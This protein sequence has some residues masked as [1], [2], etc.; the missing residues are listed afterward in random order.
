MYLMI[1]SG[2]A[3]A[4]LSYYITTDG[5]PH[6]LG[7]PA[8]MYMLSLSALLVCSLLHI[9]VHELGHVIFG[10]LSG[11]EFKGMSVLG[12]WTLRTDDGK[13]RMFFPIA[14]IGGA[15]VM[16]PK[17]GYRDDTPYTMFLMG[18]ALMNILLTMVFAAVHVLNI[19][20]LVNFFAFI[21]A[22][23]GVVMILVTLIPMTAGLGANDMCVLRLFRRDDA[24]KH[25]AYFLQKRTFALLSGANPAN[26]ADSVPADL[27]IGNRLADAV[28]LAVVETDIANRRYDAAE[29]QLLDLLKCLEDGTMISNIAKLYLI[30]I[31]TVGGADREAV[32][33]VYDDKMKKFVRAFGNT[34]L[35][36]MLFLVA[37]EKRFGTGAV[38]IDA[39]IKRF[40]AKMR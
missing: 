22:T 2:F 10:K 38:D 35:E 37:Y 32:D 12:L 13:K 36:A 9:L 16:Y 11:Y 7:G 30:F 6:D 8:W 34:D 1:I 3:L 31:R 14:G 21:G 17:D 24:S 29:T 26:Y 25:C 27:P 39:T 4:L 33:A 19:S 40:N 23:I 20:P 28:R 18:G 5:I 15:T